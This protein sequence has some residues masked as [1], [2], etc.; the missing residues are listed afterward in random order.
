MIGGAFHDYMSGM[1]SI[2][3]DGR[4]MPGLVRHFLGRHM[5]VVYNI[6]VCLL[7]L[8]VGVVFIYTPGDL[9]VTHILQGESTLGNPATWIVYGVIFAYYIVAT[10]LPIDKVIGKIYPVFGGILLLSAV[11][12]FAGLFINGYRL[13]EIWETGFSFVNPYGDSFVPIF[14]V[15]VACGI[16]S[17]FHSTQATL[18]SRT[19]RDEREGRMTFYNMMILEGFIA[20][21]W[22]AAAM[23]AVNA[24]L[25]TNAML[26]D[27][28]TAVVGIVAKD[29]LGSVGGV[30]AIIGVIV[31]PVTSGDT[32]LRSLRI[33]VM[34][35]F[36]I[37]TGRKRNNLLVALAIFSVVA[38]ILIYAKSDSKGFNVLWRYFSWANECTAVFAF[39]MISVYMM[40]NR[41]PY[42][43]ALI[44]GMFYMYVVASYILNAQ[45]GF[46]LS[47][48]ASY[49]AAGVLTLVYGAVLKIYGSGRGTG[50]ISGPG[51]QR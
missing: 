39:A 6:L 33:M 28:A 17:G 43:M 51:R 24:G 4:Q 16:V 22:A 5:F 26:H 34:D 41:M 32:S 49:T 11:G 46:N 21:V 35:T 15:T 30:I 1:I 47:W 23:G 25:A 29:M 7:M 8:L 14:F 3:H 48:T 9:F 44:P 50:R 45:I 12:V 20:M 2:R 37:D 42:L 36:H 31:L 13:D 27:Q 10:L 19:V 38:G 40:R 18:I